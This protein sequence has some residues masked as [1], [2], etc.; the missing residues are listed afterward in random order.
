M[1]STTKTEPAAAQWSTMTTPMVAALTTL[2]A[3]TA[4]S[5]IIVGSRWLGFSLL[6]VVVVSGLGLLLRGLRVHTLVVGIAQMFAVLCLLVVLFT[7]SGILGLFPG[8][9]SLHDLGGVLHDS[10]EIVK[11]GVPPVPATTPIMCLVVIAIGLVAV[12]VD[13]LAVAAAAPAACGLVLLCVYAVPASLSETMLPW[14][15]FMLGAASF[16]L[17]LAVDGTHRH[18]LGRNRAAGTATGTAGAASPA[19]LTGVALLLALLA[20]AGITMVGTIGQLPG[21][22]DGGDGAGTALGIKPF[23]SLRGMLTHE[24]NTELFRVRG[25]GQDDRYLRAVTLTTYDRNGGWKPPT[26]MPQGVPA[27]GELPPA[28]G[29]DPT[30]ATLSAIEVEPINS[31]DYWVPVYGTPHQISQLPQGIRYDPTTSMVYSEKAQKMPA[32]IEEADM[33]EPSAAEL[34]AAG[35]NYDGLDP[36]YLQRADVDPQITTLAN[37]LTSGKS[38]ELDKVLAI[39]NYF[40]PS[41]GFVYRTETSQG[42]DATALADFVFRSKAGYCEQYASSMAV[43]LRQ[44]G[45]PSRVALGYTAGFPQGDYRSIT[46]TDAHAWVEVFFP[47]RGWITFD[48]TPLSDGRAYTPAYANSTDTGGP[49]DTSTSTTNTNDDKAPK[50]EEPLPEDPTN[51]AQSTT[52]STDQQDSGVSLGWTAWVAAVLVLGAL[53]VTAS[54]WL[55]GKRKPSSA[56][57]R[58]ALTVAAYVVWTLALVFAL[59]I[60]SWWLSALAVI[61]VALAT[62]RA[63]RD[64]RRRARLHRVAGSGRD[65]ADAAWAEL[66]AESVDRGLPVQQADTVRSAARRL[67][68]EHNLDEDGK[69]GMRT[70]VNVL[71]R[72]WYGD[73][74]PDPELVKAL[75]EVRTSMRRNA[76]LAFKAKMLPRSVLRRRGI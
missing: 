35:S 64:W 43:L 65:A 15:S 4:L 59:A 14:W 10:A 34:R 13:T 33:S 72:S 74:T 68:R 22:G 37:R 27:D 36:H 11:V 70:M 60:V 32:Y 61:I 16:A 76:P 54:A 29:V 1:T 73:G 3:S 31:V 39:K 62:P 67:V 8:P 53:I 51:A 25:L 26:E 56:R 40:D 42:S 41:N 44:A 50:A 58:T 23:T 28:P 38:T 17:L 21:N 2:C 5:G 45:I 49:D 69:Q 47:G 71:E 30:D 66:L 75:E 20:G 48:P 63:V 9:S 18:R 6:A 52:G 57:L 12:L 46:T 55:I 24:G 7:N 19:A